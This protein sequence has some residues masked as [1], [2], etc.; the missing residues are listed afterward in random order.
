MTERFV[1]VKGNPRYEAS[2]AGYVRSLKTGRPMKPSEANSGYLHIKLFDGRK[3]HS[4]AVHRII[5]ESFSDEPH[6][7]LEVNHIDG[8]K[9]NNSLDNL[10]WCSHSNNTKH[11]IKNGLFKPYKLPPYRHEGRKVRI[12]ETG[13]IFGSL[14]DCAN[15][16][17]GVKQGIG[18]CLS[19]KK[20]SYKGYH[21]ESI[22]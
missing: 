12:V 9:H 6:I 10:E 21:Y 19:G 1:K 15:R 13:E 18:Q 20:K 3:H 17:S 2:S 16:V 14:T 7:G 4:K 11:A 5:A 8:N 22:D